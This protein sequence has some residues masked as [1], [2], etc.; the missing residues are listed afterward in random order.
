MEGEQVIGCRKGGYSRMERGREERIDMGRLVDRKTWSRRDVER[1]E[2]G[3][4]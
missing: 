4:K 1:K 2:R 3:V